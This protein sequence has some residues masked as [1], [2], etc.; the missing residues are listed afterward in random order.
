MNKM[1]L[2]IPAGFETER[3]H[4]RGYQAG[5]G[6]WYYPMGLRNRDHL[7]RYEADNPARTLAT[8][9]DAEALMRSFAA[10]WQARGSFF[11]GAFEKVTRSFVGQIYI[12]PMDWALPEFA[13]GYFADEA[14]TG[15]G[16][17]T[18][19]VRGALGFIF[20][21]LQAQRV[22]LECDDTNV[23]SFQVAERAG[24]IREGHLRQNKRHP[25]GTLSG[26]LLYGLLRSEYEGLKLK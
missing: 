5:D 23:R 2:D 14:H 13:V 8:E 17:I 19:A 4:V 22:R 26:T 11:L 25:D 24:F 1:L 10:D 12:G 3:L 16:Y 9:D 15:Q 6:R 21:H 18:E 20:Q 7:A